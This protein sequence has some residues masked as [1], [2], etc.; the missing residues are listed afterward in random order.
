MPK[1]E[2]QNGK[3]L[4]LSPLTFQEAVSD[5][6]QVKPPPRPQKPPQ[7]QQRPQ[8][9]RKTVSRKKTATAKK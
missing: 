4:S 7:G 9:A 5:L 1:R 6:L 3:P 8:K 2:S